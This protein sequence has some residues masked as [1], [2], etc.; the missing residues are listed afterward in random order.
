MIQLL[1]ILL[2]LNAAAADT[3]EKPL[4]LKTLHTFASDGV[5]DRNFTLLA[6]PTKSSVNLW[7]LD[8]GRQVGHIEFPKIESRH[9]NDYHEVKV[10]SVRPDLK[11]L[12]VSVRHLFYNPKYTP[13]GG[14]P[15]MASAVQR[16]YLASTEDEKKLTLLWTIEGRCVYLGGIQSYHCPGTDIVGTTRISDDRPEVVAGVRLYADQGMVIDRVFDLT[17]K[18]LFENKFLYADWDRAKKDYVPA[19]PEPPFSIVQDDQSCSV[20]RGDKR[21]SFLEGCVKDDQ[22]E[23][24][25]DKKKVISRWNA[26]YKAWD[27]ESGALTAR[28]GLEVPAG[29]STGYS[30]YGVWT[31]SADGRVA[32]ILIHKGQ[33]SQV[34]IWNAASGRKM[35]V[36]SGP[37][38][39]DASYFILA[40][41]G[42]RGLYAK[43]KRTAT[44]DLE[45]VTTVVADLGLEDVPP[46]APSA[47]TIA[48][49]DV[50]VLPTGSSAANPDAFAVVIGVEKYR[51]AGVPAVDYASRDAKTMAAYLGTMG[52]DAKNVAVLTDAQAGKVDFDKYFGKWLKNRV[53]PKSRVFVYYAGHGAPNPTTGAGYLMPYEADPAYLEE[54][55]Y[56][57][58]QLYAELAKLPTKDVTVVLDACFSGQGERSLIAKGTRPLVPVQAAS[59]PENAAVIAAASGSQISASDHEARHG[60][61]TY[62]LLSGLHGEAD[63]NSDGKI[64]TSELFAYARPAVERA[65]KLQNVEQT[66]TVTG[67]TGTA[68]ARVWTTLKKP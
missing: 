6:T 14:M 33:E 22:P 60:L 1:P 25:M 47:P 50:D 2:A 68:G 16:L 65:A 29:W 38:L 9:E 4:A 17:G 7:S 40:P 27:A 55:A 59:G 3:P 12:F 51:Q 67:V 43:Y 44:G 35:A 42:R 30:A 20:M 19:S 34:H 11:V 37:D 57:V 52:F 45:S 48:K 23:L 31:Q 66:P 63:A 64:T 39:E 53:G 15:N 24:S 32:S 54:T 58:T 18:K 61:L 49:V 5:I 21:V 36:G 46:A 8:T 56:P 10:H 26:V 28:L 41:N 13:D 62:H